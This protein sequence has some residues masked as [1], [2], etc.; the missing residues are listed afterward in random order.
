MAA[1]ILEASPELCHGHCFGYTAERDSW[2]LPEI[3]NASDKQARPGYNS[4]DASEYQDTPDVLAAKV[5]VLAELVRRA[6]K[7]VA[8]TGAGLS[9]AAG[10][11]DYASQT[12]GPNPM[13]GGLRS[14]MC[15]QPT[16]AHRVLVALHSAGRLHRWVNQNHDGL[17]QKAGLPQQHINEIHGAWHAPDNPVVQM[18]GNLRD[19]LF[20]DLLAWEEQTDLV[21]AVGTSLAGMNADRLVTSAAERAAADGCGAEQ[22]GAV[23]VGLQRTTLD[24]CATLRIFA[25]CDDVFEALAKELELDVHAAPTPGEFWVPAALRGLDEADFVFDVPYDASGRLSATTRSRLDLREDAELVIPTGMYAGALG[26]V[27]G[28]D[29]EGNIKCR[30]KLKAP[31]GKL[32]APMTLVLGRW[33]I[34]AAVEGA[35]P[36]LPV[37]NKPSEGAVDSEGL[38]PIIQAIAAYK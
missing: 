18:S 19:D 33:W 36:L 27:D 24:S 16:L 22:L 2:A 37:V 34:Q 21:L 11:G 29:R 26:E 12:E 35:V 15:A 1:R 38:Q 7:A 9:T 31:K 30:F 3:I 4:L 5:R 23:V 14:P 13:G 10:I 8:Y 20:N 6:C 25:R 32:R 17:P 28:Y